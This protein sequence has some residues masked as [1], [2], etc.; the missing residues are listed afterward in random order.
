[1]T[2]L[3]PCLLLLACMQPCL[4]AV[5]TS[6]LYISPEGN[7]A[8]TG[9]AASHT[10]GDK[11]PLAT[12]S[13]AMKRMRASR[14]TK[15]PV[16]QLI[17]REGSHYLDETI[18]LTAEDSGTRRRPLT[19]THYPGEYPR[20]VGGLKLSPKLDAPPGEPLNYNFD[21]AL[22]KIPAPREG[23][24]GKHLP[25]FEVFAN[26]QR[27]QIA[28]WPD[29]NPNRP[30]HEN[31]A[32]IAH[33]DRKN[34][35][36]RFTAHT[37]PSSPVEI[38]AGEGSIQAF[39][40][41]NWYDRIMDIASIDQASRQVEVTTKPH[42]R[43]TPGARFALLDFRAALDAPGEWWFDRQ[44]QELL[45]IPFANG[46]PDFEIEVSTLPTLLAI[47]GAKHIRIEGISWEICTGTAIT[48]T[49]ADDVRIAGNTIGLTGY[50]AIE[51]QTDGRLD[52]R[53]NLI[54]SVGRAGVRLTGGDRDKLTPARITA[55][56]NRIAGLGERIKCYAPAF[57]LRGVG[58]RV[59]GNHLEDGPHNAIQFS[60]NEHRIERNL[61]E[62]F[63]QETNDVG[64]IYA[65][66]DWSTRGNLI[67][68][69]MIRHL[70]GWEMFTPK[71]QPE[72]AP[73]HVV[74]R[75][76][77]KIHGVYLDD[78]LEDTTVADNTFEDISSGAVHLGG[79]GHT[80]IT[81]NRFDR[82]GSALFVSE[83]NSFEI[84]QKGLDSYSDNPIWRAKYPEIINRETRTPLF[85]SGIRFAHNAIGTVDLA[86]RI[87][88]LSAD[89]HFYD[90]AFSEKYPPIQ[91]TVRTAKKTHKFHEWD[92]W[93]A[94]GF[95]RHW[96]NGFK[97][98]ASS[99]PSPPSRPKLPK[100]EAQG[101]CCRVAPQAH[102][103]IDTR[104]NFELSLE[105]A[106]QD[107]INTPTP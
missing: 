10:N 54:W 73:L 16:H 100:L 62:N 24:L 3:V 61:I 11:G 67:K 25:V 5:N 93:T 64:A 19:I 33:A 55:R 6:R 88:R 91:A 49:D 35:P 89:N 72:D 2:R 68:G 43:F 14:A 18:L 74:Y 99:L 96:P 76:G 70:Y 63:A 39:T 104:H 83:R 47:N 90:N 48:I 98:R 38:P 102:T 85:P 79:G 58:I 59:T 13:E 40:Q 57:R 86:Y 42:Y 29:W 106:P 53:Q 87:Y 30:Y 95:D 17:L 32:Y 20:V 71:D 45:V 46:T 4:F 52:I 60:G 9:F 7:D 23:R 37:L 15:N 80:T 65:G 78:M 12:I 26:R 56:G 103:V 92:S 41:P 36:T 22:A 21:P 66:R 107:Q 82:V 81:G 51:A 75:Q 27:L 77:T 8:W 31:W 69:N 34:A 94:L 97:A 50:D 28:R 44:T 84:A 1:M 101:V 105:A